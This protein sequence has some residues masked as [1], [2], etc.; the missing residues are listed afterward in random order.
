[1]NLKEMNNIFKFF[2]NAKNAIKIL[3]VKTIL[4]IEQ[5]TAFKYKSN[6]MF[7]LDYNNVGV[8]LFNMQNLNFTPF[9][10]VYLNFKELKSF[11]FVFT[12]RFFKH[13]INLHN[14]FRNKSVISDQ[15]KKGSQMEK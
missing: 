14:I 3:W 10:S 8:S 1:M 12:L 5:E 9:Q 4:R 13:F 15:I 7:F 6:N 2:I 11:K